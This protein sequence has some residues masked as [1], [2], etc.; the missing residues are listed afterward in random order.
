MFEVT[1]K[2][3]AALI[4]FLPA[5]LV[6]VWMT[7]WKIVAKVSVTALL[8]LL[9]K[10]TV[11]ARHGSQPGTQ[12]AQTMVPTTA[13]STTTTEP[14]HFQTTTTAPPATSPAST[15]PPAAAEPSSDIVNAGS[16]C[17][18][19]GALGVTAAGTPVI[20]CTSATDSRLRWRSRQV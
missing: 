20:C 17:S 12:A 16:Y 18:P 13:S 1:N 5:G 2:K 15:A 7:K 10:V 3:Q 6:L 9:V 19:A 8:A 4:A 11:A 14:K